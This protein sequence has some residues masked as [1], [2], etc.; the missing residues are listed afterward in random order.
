MFGLLRMH[1][2]LFPML[3]SLLLEAGPP[4]ADPKDP[5]K[6]TPKGEDP[7]KTFTQDA[8]NS[9]VQRRLDEEKARIEKQVRDELTEDAKK[10]KLE[11]EKRWEELAETRKQEAEREKNAR[12]EAEA[13]ARDRVVRSE[14]RMA[15]Q[16]MNAA[17]ADD[18]YALLDKSKIV[19]DEAGEPTNIPALVKALLEA[20]PHLVKVVDGKGTPPATRGNGLPRITRDDIKNHYLTEAGVK[21]PG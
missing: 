4:A 1:L 2:A 5:P 10:Q 18:V 3:L 19:Y 13:K 9:I 11:D 14:V 20:K 16:E 21:T 15:A 12:I 17:D 8:V 7:P 6:D